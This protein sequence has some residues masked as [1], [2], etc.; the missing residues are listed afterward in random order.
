MTAKGSTLVSTLLASHLLLLLL[1][2]SSAR[3]DDVA[4]DDKL[5]QSINEYR[6]SLNLTTLSR[7]ANAACLADQMAQQ[8]KSQACT[9]TTG[10]DT[11]PGTE[12]QLSNYPDLL[13]NCHLN[14]SNTR[15]GIVMPACVP[16]LV[17]AVVLS[18]FTKSQYS[19]YLNDTKYIGAGIASEN[20]WI[21][22]VLSTD[23]SAGSFEADTSGSLMHYKPILSHHFLA[24]LLGLLL[25][26]LC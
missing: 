23:T 18:N 8:F 6:K 2:P 3:A 22:V 5:L 17:P 4:G 21:V 15:D 13:A 19:E 26:T 7:N 9:N 25:F 20:D 24:M 11:V 12:T 14:I 16:G 1:L 10:S